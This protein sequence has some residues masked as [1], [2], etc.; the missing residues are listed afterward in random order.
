MLNGL[1]LQAHSATHYPSKF[2]LRESFTFA[3]SEHCTGCLAFRH[4]FLRQTALEA[5]FPI[6]KKLVVMYAYPLQ[7]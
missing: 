4:T 3:A 1:R 2:L 7:K 6:K 5:T